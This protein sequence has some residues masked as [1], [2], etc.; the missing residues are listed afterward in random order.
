[1][2]FKLRFL[3]NL[4]YLLSSRYSSA[5]SISVRVGLLSTKTCA[6]VRPNMIS[7]KA[8]CVYSMPILFVIIWNELCSS[9]RVE[10]MYSVSL[11]ADYGEHKSLSLS[12]N[13]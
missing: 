8:A 5:V 7:C 9:W 10:P 1:M 6:K 2:Y 13:Y 12:L 3:V 4:L 11:T